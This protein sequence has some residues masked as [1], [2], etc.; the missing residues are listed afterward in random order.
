MGHKYI[1][2]LGFFPL[3]VYDF[4]VAH[5]LL[6]WWSCA[7]ILENVLDPEEAQRPDGTHQRD[8]FLIAAH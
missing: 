1:N 4:S 8:P 3:V 7:E 2:L 6:L 5:H